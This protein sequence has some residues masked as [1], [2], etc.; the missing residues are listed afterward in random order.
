MSND[1]V[2]MGW[3]AANYTT[4]A[5]Y[6]PHGLNNDKKDHMIKSSQMA[7]RL[8]REGELDFGEAHIYDY[9]LAQNEVVYGD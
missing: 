5:D 3:T 9:R 8:N 1:Y 6:N 4:H 7:A 2:P